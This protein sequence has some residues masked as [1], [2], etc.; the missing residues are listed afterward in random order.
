LLLIPSLLPELSS[1]QTYHTQFNSGLSL[2]H[3]ATT[4]GIVS[5]P[6]ARSTT[7]LLGQEISR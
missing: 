1:Q 7:E 5:D 6:E 2:N 3:R 4:A